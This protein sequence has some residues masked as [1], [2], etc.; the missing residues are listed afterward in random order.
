[1]GNT[2]CGAKFLLFQNPAME[3]PKTRKIERY[4]GIK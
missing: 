3:E 4:F 1:M 2:S